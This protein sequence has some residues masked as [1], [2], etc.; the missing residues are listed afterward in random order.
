[1][2]QGW[3]PPPYPPPPPEPRQP[4]SGLP[5]WARLLLGAIAGPFVLGGSAIPAGILSSVLVNAGVTGLDGLVGLLGLALPLA[6]LIGGLAWR[7]T[8]WYAVGA[9]IGLAVLFIVLA[10]VCVA[11]L[12]SLQS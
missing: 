3:S 9:L 2:S 11:I 10:G 1:M 8:R 5:I 6:V 7:P 4:E 12:A